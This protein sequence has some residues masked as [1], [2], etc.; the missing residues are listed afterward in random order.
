MIYVS[1][2][3]NM[4]EYYK[5]IYNYVYH[6]IMLDGSISDDYIFSDDE[7]LEGVIISG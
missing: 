5:D 6:P 2:E 4:I 3:S 7:I 1:N